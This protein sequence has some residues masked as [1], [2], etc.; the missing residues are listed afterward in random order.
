MVYHVIFKKGLL[1]KYGKS[2]HIYLVI[3]STFQKQSLRP[4]FRHIWYAVDV[5]SKWKNQGRTGEG[6]MQ[7]CSRPSCFSW[8]L[9]GTI[10]CEL[11]HRGFLALREGAWPLETLCQSIN[12]YGLLQG[13]AEGIPSLAR[14]L[15][16][17]DK[18]WRR[19]AIS[20]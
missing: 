3:K 9:Q 11:Y 17:K 1:G 18:S 10:Q 5:F 4:R 14:Q 20:H 15:S 19:A 6:G 16:A 12:G 8:I 13:F 7:Q 2:F